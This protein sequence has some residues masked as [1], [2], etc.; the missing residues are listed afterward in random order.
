LGLQNF[1]PTRMASLSGR[2]DLNFRARDTVNPILMLWI[3]CDG[4]SI[5]ACRAMCG[6]RAA[7]SQD[8]Q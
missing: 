6:W 2:N 5:L 8:W 3:K 7:L 4:L 1:L